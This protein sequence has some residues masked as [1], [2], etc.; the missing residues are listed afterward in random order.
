ME[1]SQSMES[2][3]EKSL[4]A[5]SS[6]LFAK[7]LEI[8][9][10][11]QQ[12]TKN[13]SSNMPR[14]QDSF[15]PPSNNETSKVTRP[16]TSN[17]SSTFELPLDLLALPG[18]LPS[19]TVTKRDILK[20]STKHRK[21]QH[22]KDSSKVEPGKSAKSETKKKSEAKL[23]TAKDPVSSRKIEATNKDTKDDSKQI[24]E[25]TQS[26][27]PLDIMAME[28]EAISPPLDEVQSDISNEASES[29]VI[30][31]DDDMYMYDAEVFDDNVS[32]TSSS[33]H[34]SPVPLT[35]TVRRSVRLASQDSRG[36]A[37]KKIPRKEKSITPLQQNEEAV[38]NTDDAHK[39]SSRKRQKA[40]KLRASKPQKKKRAVVSSSSSEEELN[41]D[42]TEIAVVAPSTRTQTPPTKIQTPP[43]VSTGRRSF[44]KR[45]SIP[46]RRLSSSSMP[47]VVTRS[48]QRR[49]SDEQQQQEEEE[50]TKELDDESIEEDV[51][52]KPKRLKRK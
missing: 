3:I 26:T 47:S 25:S 23:D 32:M 21:H 46:C 40:E 28:T 41:M 24:K 45:L 6:E 33:K 18:L 49:M 5:K 39:R 29:I 17:P 42:D 1:V 51:F 36:D 52:E 31:E 7:I 19:N 48:A 10:T 22:D 14:P 15:M 16:G 30:D 35:K 34:A 9:D 50:R 37:T 12:E 8:I 13:D 11:I 38:C 2:L 27:K 43:P 4:E 44:S 20:K